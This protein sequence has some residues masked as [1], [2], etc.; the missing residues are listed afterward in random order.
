MSYYENFSQYETTS[1]MLDSFVCS[2]TYPK[3]MR[4]N[5]KAIKKGLN[6]PIQI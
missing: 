5:M 6:I 1:F 2:M 4:L 3:G